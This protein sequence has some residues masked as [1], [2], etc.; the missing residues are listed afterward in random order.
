MRTE[1]GWNE[2]ILAVGAGRETIY[3]AYDVLLYML[4][5]RVTMELQARKDKIAHARMLDPPPNVERQQG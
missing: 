1:E 4:S 5:C 3:E 2:E